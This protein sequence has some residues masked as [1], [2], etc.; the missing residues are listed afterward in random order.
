[1]AQ[2]IDRLP[3][4]INRHFSCWVIF[5]AILGAHGSYSCFAEDSSDIAQQLKKDLAKPVNPP[6]EKPDPPAPSG[7][8]NGKVNLFTLGIEDLMNIQVTS[9]ARRPEKRTEA[10]A[11]IH[12]ITGE[13]IRRSGVTTIAE[14]LRMAPGLDVARGGSHSWAIS[15]RG[16]NETV[17][18]HLLVLID[19]RSVYTP[20]FSGT[21]WEAQDTMLEDIDRI[22]VIRGPGA[23]LWG[24]NAM[25]GVINV[26]TKS[27]K[28]TEGGLATVG[29]GTYE[30]GFSSF[31]YGAKI[32]PNAYFRAY[33]KYNQRDGFDTPNGHEAPDGWTTGQ[34]GFRLDFDASK[35]DLLTVQGD[36][37]RAELDQRSIEPILVPPFSRVNSQDLVDSGGNVLGRWSHTFSERSNMALQ[38][39]FDRAAT[40]GG[41]D[42]STDTF[43]IDFQDKISTDTRNDIVW[44][45][46]YRH[47]SD[48]IISPESFPTER[49]RDLFSAFA[50]DEVSI[51]E[52]R[53]SLTLGS[54]FEHNDFTGFEVQP[55]ARLLWLPQERHSV[56][57]AV[58][59]AVRTP[60]RGEEDVRLPQSA[61][62]PGEL[63]PGSPVGL[64]TVLGNRDFKS[65]NLRA[66]ELGYRVQ[67]HSKL[68]LD[69]AGFY[70]VYDNLR[71]FEPGTPF[72]ESNPLPLHLIVPVREANK[73]N[74]TTYGGEVSAVWQAMQRWRLRA[75]YSN[76]NMNLDS[77]PR[78]TDTTSSK[79]D[80]DSPRHQFSVRSSIDLP[81]NVECDF[82]LRYVSRLPNRDVPAYVTADVRAGWRPTKMLDLSIVGQNLLDPRHPEF[83]PA[84]VK[85]PPSEVPRSI[86][87]KLTIKF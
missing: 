27:A 19:G 38:M 11:A 26:V 52:K 37:Y 30:E 59:R 9:V 82:D 10:P 18:S 81:E 65:E 74:A 79:Q 75:I 77:D 67:P 24:A 48:K 62:P 28:D 68:S 76:L 63:G 61:I 31:R 2:L 42:I 14:A 72:L 7:N 3:G 6:G 1:M 32:A 50:Q 5:L 86:Y 29:G 60:S 64:V 53:L 43:D 20:V 57:A 78:S 35:E 44:G 22:E 51:L 56:W 13:E 8:G 80:G 16:F 17:A 15:S 41:R 66:Y 39:Y 23:T 71:S 55:S 70:N 36:I 58:S 33:S 47:L 85:Q 46:G 83:T 21:I 45:A 4:W 40:G 73:L 49:E 87:L 34:G 25:D 84:F 54:K 12:V 69:F